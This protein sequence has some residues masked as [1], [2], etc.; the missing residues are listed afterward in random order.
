MVVPPTVRPPASWV[1]PTA[2]TVRL[3]AVFTVPSTMAL[4]SVNWTALAPVLLA[5]TAPVKSLPAAVRVMTPAPAFTV[6]VPPTVRPPASW[7]TPEVAVTSK[8]PTALI[9]P[10]ATTAPLTKMLLPLKVAP[11]VVTLPVAIRLWSPVPV[12][13]VLVAA[14]KMPPAPALSDTAPL[15]VLMLSLTVIAPLVAL[16]V[17]P[18][19]D[20]APAEMAA[21][22]TMP[23]FAV[24]TTVAVPIW[25]V[26]ASLE[27]LLS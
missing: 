13:M 1:T 8:V 21:F 20:T 6:V 26:I 22:T 9:V 16:R 18:L 15:F 12:E 11:V 2:L 19:P 3:L 14:T 23:L 5:E 25:V 24:S 10:N 27:I 7:V 17:S 4:V